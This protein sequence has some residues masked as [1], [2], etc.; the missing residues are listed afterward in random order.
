MGVKNIQTDKKCKIVLRRG[1]PVLLTLLFCIIS[2]V[3][4]FTIVHMQGNARVINYAGIIRGATQR[5][6]KQEMNGTP[7]DDLMAYLSEILIELSTGEGD[8]NLIALDDMEYQELMHKMRYSWLEL[9]D[10]IMSVRKSGE[11]DKLFE[12]S[13]TYFAL[14]DQAVSAAERY[15]EESVGHAKITLIC[16]NIGFVALLILFWIYGRRQK[17]IQLALDMAENANKAKSEFLS[18]MSHEIRT[19]MNGII[20]MTEIARMSIDDREKVE[21]CLNKI[22]LSSGYL[23]SLINDILDMSRIESGRLELSQ[24]VFSLTEMTDR[25]YAMFQQRAEQNDITL[26]MAPGDLAVDAVIGDTLRISQILINIIANALKFTPSGGQ[27]SFEIR[28]TEILKQRVALEFVITDTGIGIG[29]E[30]QS[31]LF[32]PFEQEG[33]STSRQYG[34]TGLGLAISNNFVKM[35]GGKIIVHSTL[36]K[37]SQFIVCLTLNRPEQDP[38]DGEALKSPNRFPAAS[39]IPNDFTGISI[40]LAEDNAINA[41]IARTILETNGASVDTVYNGKEA[42]DTFSASAQHTYDLI[43]MDVQMPVMNG[44]DAS[45]AI[46]ALD[47]L[48]AQKVFIIGVSANAFQEDINNALKSGMNGYLSKPIDPGQLFDTITRALGSA[49][50]R[51]TGNQL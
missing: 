43:L 24:E 42:L 6:V 16:L 18:R 9:K 20:G 33:S 38:L 39:E 2:T 46:R 34:G 27:V 35:M 1:I 50:H 17:Q 11:T 12:L 41:E 49:P 25:I 5:L 44:L 30:F 26:Q 7:N 40:L 28:Q 51:K 4:L 36:H 29:K 37:G 13:E 14:A 15:S 8:H 31:R 10:E 48:D 47:R 45:L 22:D 32:E 21:D 19:P 23:L 3:S